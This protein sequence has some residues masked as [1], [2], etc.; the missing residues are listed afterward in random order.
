MF[1]PIVTCS[2]VHDA[3]SVN[4]AKNFLPKRVTYGSLPETGSWLT[5]ALSSPHTLNFVTTV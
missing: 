5:F 3:K 1:S 4:S 2:L